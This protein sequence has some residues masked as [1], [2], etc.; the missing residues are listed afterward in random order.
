MID[1]LMKDLQTRMKKA[2][3]VL[4]DELSGLRTGRASTSLIEN[5]NVEAYGSPMPLNQLASLSTP[6]PRLI[7]VQPWDKGV[8]KAIEKAIRESELGLN[9]SNDG[10]IIRVPLPEL[11]EERRKELAKQLHKYGEG[12]KVAVR[13][14]R[15]D[16]MET[17]KKAEKD[18]EISQD[19]LRHHEKQV[20]EITD[21]FT[22]QIDEMVAHKEED[23]MTV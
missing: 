14:I 5:I 7:A 16:G 3:A 22:K 4:K 8:A 9:P 18:K 10:Q 23:I 21:D 12:C 11:T 6:E 17:L 2:L 20:Q 1:P 15:R 13:N 19:D